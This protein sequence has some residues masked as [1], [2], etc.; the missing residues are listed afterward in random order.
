M[1]LGDRTLTI[2]CQVFQSQTW[3]HGMGQY[4]LALLRALASAGPDSYGRVHLVFNRLLPTAEDRIAILRETW[5]GAGGV[6][7]TRGT[8]ALINS[9][10]IQSKIPCSANAS[11]TRLM[12]SRPPSV[13][14]YSVGST[15]KRGERSRAE[16]DARYGD[17]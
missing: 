10:G 6:C 16:P 11:R 4:S 17:A 2:D 14:P 9:T 5:P 13:P 3:H 7:A 15:K 8:M 1:D 12:P